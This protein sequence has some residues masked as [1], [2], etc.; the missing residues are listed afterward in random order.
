[1]T[2]NSNINNFLLILKPLRYNIIIIDISM[3]NKIPFV[4][5]ANN[6]IN[7]KTNKIPLDTKL[8]I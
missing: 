1:M 6:T 7:K 2:K 8:P 4:F 3:L 5:E